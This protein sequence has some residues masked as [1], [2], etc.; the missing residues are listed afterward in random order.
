MFPGL[1][2]YIQQKR[3]GAGWPIVRMPVH[4]PQYKIVSANWCSIKA[5]YKGLVE[6]T[7]KIKA[8]RERAGT[9]PCSS[10]QPLSC[11]HPRLL[12]LYRLLAIHNILDAKHL[13]CRHIQQLSRK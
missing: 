13:S 7:G 3:I 10:M 12:K 8:R 9:P 6:A 11:L 2:E 4:A 5:Y 1:Q